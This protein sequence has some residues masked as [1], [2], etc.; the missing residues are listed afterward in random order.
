MATIGNIVTVRF[1]DE[2]GVAEDLA[3]RIT[4]GGPIGGTW[5]LA[6]DG[7]EFLAR[8]EVISLMADPR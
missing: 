1:I 2:E 8:G 3:V 4:G 5:L 7:R 6:E